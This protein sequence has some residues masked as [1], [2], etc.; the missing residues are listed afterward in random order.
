MRYICSE[1]D[2][3]RELSNFSVSVSPCAKCSC[4]K[5]TAHPLTDQS[6]QHAVSLLQ[7]TVPTLRM[8]DGVFR[9]A[10]WLSSDVCTGSRAFVEHGI[11][12]ASSLHRGP[13]T[14]L[15]ILGGCI[16]LRGDFI[17]ST[18][19]HYRGLILLLTLLH[20]SVVRPSSSRD[21]LTSAY[22]TS[23]S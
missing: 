5:T 18:Q 11:G 10:R 22:A 13:H 23:L 6:R 12:W 2:T 17:P 20:V 16:Q 9:N 4:S 8:Q 3:R 14:S 7:R 1:E 15:S 19:L 21:I